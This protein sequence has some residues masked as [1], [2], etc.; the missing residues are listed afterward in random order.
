MCVHCRGRSELRRKIGNHQSLTKFEL[1]GCIRH[2]GKSGL[3]VC[4]PTVFPSVEHSIITVSASH[5]CPFC[6]YY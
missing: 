3:G 1:T 4:A 6:I 2:H 5:N